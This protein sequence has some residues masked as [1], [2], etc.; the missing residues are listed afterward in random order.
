[1]KF[2]FD[3][4]LSRD[5]QFSRTSLNGAVTQHKNKDIKTIEN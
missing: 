3:Q 4:Y 5:I 1:M 2:F